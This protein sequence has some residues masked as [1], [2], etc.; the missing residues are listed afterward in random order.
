MAA[1]GTDAIICV[2]CGTAFGQAVDEVAYFDKKGFPPPTRCGDC[3][4]ASRTARAL[5]PVAMP[6]HKGGAG[7]KLPAPKGGS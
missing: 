5:K 4:A 7:V 2:G 3:R 1:S 6:G